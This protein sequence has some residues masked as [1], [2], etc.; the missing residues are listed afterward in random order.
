MGQ[1]VNPIGL[2]VGI[3]R[4]WDSRWYANRNFAE[5]L[6]RLEALRATHFP[7][8]EGRKEASRTLAF[9]ETI[10][11]TPASAVLA[12]LAFAGMIVGLVVLALSEQD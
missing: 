3:N 6:P 9:E 4:T 1:K 10:H 7:P 2:R 8:P 11:E 5:L 12:M